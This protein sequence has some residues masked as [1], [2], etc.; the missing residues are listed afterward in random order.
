MAALGVAALA[1]GYSFL[2]SATPEPAEAV[3][4]VIEGPA[5]PLDGSAVQLFF[6]AVDGLLHLEARSLAVDPTLELGDR[7]HRL[8]HE[9]VTALLQE[10]ETDGLR[11]AFDEGTEL[12][13]VRISR[14]GVAIVSLQPGP[15][16]VNRGLGSRAELLRVYSL[17]NSLAYSV[18]GVVSVAI[19]WAGSQPTTLA[20]HVD[21]SR[22]LLPSLDWV[23]RA[24]RRQLST[25]ARK[26]EP[27]KDGPTKD[28]ASASAP[29]AAPGTE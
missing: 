3:D 12:A 19:V 25:G 20:G 15:G 24:S 21:T 13:Q 26:D 4:G 18:D 16:S 28:G 10:P 8:A 22:P 17:V 5:I 2:G 11:R 7:R 9:V 1:L 14:D 27:S 29:S 23:V 6:P